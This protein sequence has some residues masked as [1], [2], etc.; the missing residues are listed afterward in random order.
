ARMTVMKRFGDADDIAWAAVYLAS[1]E[2]K[3]VTG[4]V[5]S[6][7]GGYVMSQ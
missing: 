7:N 4:Q 6:P 3:F 2:A 5:L 1:D